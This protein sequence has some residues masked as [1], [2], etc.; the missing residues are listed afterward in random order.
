M[1]SLSLSLSLGIYLSIYICFTHTHTHIGAYQWSRSRKNKQWI[2]LIS[3]LDFIIIDS[4]TGS[5]FCLHKRTF[6]PTHRL[7]YR[8]RLGLQHI[9]RRIIWR[10]SIKAWRRC[11]CAYSAHHLSTSGLEVEVWATA[12]MTYSS[13]CLPFPFPVNEY[14]EIIYSRIVQISVL[15]GIYNVIVTSCC[16]AA[17]I[18]LR[19]LQVLTTPTPRF[20]VV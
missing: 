18:C 11:T 4:E 14:F 2:T 7:A 3:S 5:I 17:T 8:R 13:Q 15:A 1:L 10:R 9:A 6:T 16:G 19:P 12:G 20:R